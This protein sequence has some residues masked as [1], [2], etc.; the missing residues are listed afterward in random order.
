MAVSDKD[1]AILNPRLDAA[2]IRENMESKKAFVLKEALGRDELV[3]IAA[4]VSE[5]E[6]LYW[7][8]SWMP[9]S[10]P[11]REFTPKVTEEGLPTY[12]VCLPLAVRLLQSEPYKFKLLDPDV[13]KIKMPAINGGEESKKAYKH[14]YKKDSNG[15]VV[16]TVSG[17]PVLIPDPKV[18]EADLAAS[19][20]KN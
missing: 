20:G 16:F 11:S 9:A 15:K 14:I 18:V 17:M 2:V 12:R 3:T 5:Q 19:K 10:E 13:L 4:L 6:C 7:R 8:D 1:N